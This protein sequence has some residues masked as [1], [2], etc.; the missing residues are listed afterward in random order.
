MGWII[1]YKRKVTYSPTR[2]KPDRKF[3]MIVK[4][5]ESDIPKI[6]LSL[7]KRKYLDIE[8]GKTTT[9]TSEESVSKIYDYTKLDSS[10]RLELITALKAEDY[11]E[12]KRITVEN[13]VISCRTCLY[14][15]EDAKEWIE[16]EMKNGFLKIT[17]V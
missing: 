13:K 14:S 10:Q 2:V 1:I 16:H 4:G 17:H 6:E 7:S 15:N 8:T 9:F 12:I 5:K 3:M 11:K